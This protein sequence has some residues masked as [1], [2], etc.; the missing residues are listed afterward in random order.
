MHRFHTQWFISN[1]WLLKLCWPERNLSW[2]VSDELFPL[3]C[4]DHQA[5]V[6]DVIQALSSAVVVSVQFGSAR[7]LDVEIRLQRMSG[8]VLVVQ[9]GLFG[10]V[11]VLRSIIGR[12]HALPP[13]LLRF[14]FRDAEMVDDLSLW[15]Q[16]VR[17]GDVLSLV[18]SGPSDTNS[19][20]ARVMHDGTWPMGRVR[21]WQP[22]L[23]Q[24]SMR[25]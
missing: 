16:G 10:R 13:S 14:V 22:G 4:L 17:D 11:P 19:L 6:V 1:R 7:L 3:S 24:C 20:P 8:R 15:D 9:Y 5:F 25:E 21:P 2:D 23:F 18:I 12:E